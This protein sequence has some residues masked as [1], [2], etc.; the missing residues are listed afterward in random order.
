MPT[1][2]PLLSP[3]AIGGLQL[4]NRVA[5]APMSRVSTRGDGVP[6]RAM[7]EYYAA[8]ARGAFG[9]IISEGTYTDHAHAQAYPDQPA[10][11]TGEQLDAWRQVTDAV[12]AEGGHIFLQLMHAGALVQGNAHR[13]QAIAPS[14]VAP[15]GRML[16]GYGG[17]GGAYATPREASGEDLADAVQGFADSARRAQDAGFDGV[18]V[19]AANGYLLDQFITRD[20][21]LRE[22]EY[23][24]RPANR[25]RLT[26]EVVSAA[27]AATD[28]AFPVGVRI[29]QAKVNDDAYR[30]HGADEASEILETLAL[31]GP[32]F[33]HV[34]GEGGGWHEGSMLADGTSLPRLAR[35]L[36]GV[37]VIGNGGIAAAELATELLLEG[38]ADLVA[39]G[40]AAL[41]NPDWP[42]RLAEGREPEPFDGAMLQSAVTIEHAARWRAERA[43]AAARDEQLVTRTSRLDPLRRMRPPVVEA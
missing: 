23:G 19:H 12:H 29:S 18:E 9:L 43:G 14:A 1:V 20:T 6:T 21:N 17:P 5:V 32:A 3:V 36:C 38:H 35:R 30:W 10:I 41:A 42:A 27:R 25:A 15:K 40:Q 34:A 37:P 13:A 28:R 2:H 22:D 16:A 33:V 4:P 24:G 7:V 11:V 26:A 8:F 39:L 31:A